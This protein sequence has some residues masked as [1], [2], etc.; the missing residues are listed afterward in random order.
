MT[1]LLISMGIG[2]SLGTV[3]GVLKDPLFGLTFKF[4]TNNLSKIARGDHL[5]AEEKEF[6]KKYNSRKYIYNG[7]DYTQ[8]FRIMSFSPGMR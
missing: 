8:Q 4:A 5:N 7:I 1:S 3:I 2:G 6:I